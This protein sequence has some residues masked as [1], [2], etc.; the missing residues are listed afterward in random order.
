MIEW[1][2]ITALGAF[3]GTALAVWGVV[4]KAD[5]VYLDHLAGKF[6]T[7]KDFERLETKV[8]RLL[9]SLFKTKNH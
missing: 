6:A 8:D 4:G 3:A 1:T 5:K 2:Q 9:L 7:K